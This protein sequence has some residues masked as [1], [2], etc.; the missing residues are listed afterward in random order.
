LIFHPK[1]YQS[2]FIHLY[3][4]QIHTLKPYGLQ[5]DPIETISFQSSK[6]PFAATSMM[7]SKGPEGPV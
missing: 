2:A 4:Q 7:V 1:V 3:E 5:D 6:Q